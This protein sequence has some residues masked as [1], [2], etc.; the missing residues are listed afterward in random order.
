MY[1]DELFS[2]SV[3]NLMG[4]YGVE[5][6]KIL[7]PRF[8]VPNL[9]DELAVIGHRDGSV[10]DLLVELVW[11]IYELTYKLSLLRLYEEGDELK[12]YVNQ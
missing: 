12:K 5:L 1:C 4:K 3:M 10:G 11:S 2:D 6:T 7:D 8:G 9:D